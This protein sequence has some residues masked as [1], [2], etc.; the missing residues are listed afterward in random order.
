MRPTFAT[1]RADRLVATSH[2]PIRCAYRAQKP[3]ARPLCRRSRPR[4]AGH[5]STS[6]VAI[7]AVP[8]ATRDSGEPI[9]APRPEMKAAQGSAKPVR[10]SA[11]LPPD[12]A[13]HVPSS[14]EAEAE[15]TTVLRQGRKRMLRD[16]FSRG[17][18]RSLPWHLAGFDETAMIA[19][20]PLGRSSASSDSFLSVP[21]G[22]RRLR[23]ASAHPRT[24]EGPPLCS[25]RLTQN[26]R[27][28]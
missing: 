2:H 23:P 17:D 19:C 4:S 18:R 24:W 3:G 20:E 14:I 8:E 11:P 10:G 1:N 12:A 16:D 26:G 21:Q 27:N 15:A 7:V 28:E 25:S 9:V 13:E 5:R 6:Q 22:D